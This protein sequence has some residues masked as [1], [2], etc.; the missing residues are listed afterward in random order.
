[1]CS[2]CNSPGKC[3]W[4]WHYSW[5]SL[6]DTSIQN[7]RPFRW[8]SIK[9]ASDSMWKGFFMHKGPRSH[10]PLLN[11]RGEAQWGRCKMF[12]Q[13]SQGIRDFPSP[14]C[15]VACSASLK[16]QKWMGTRKFQSLKSCVEATSASPHLVLELIVS[17][18]FWFSQVFFLR[19]QIL[20]GN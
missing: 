13:P 7:S 11:G 10:A 14:S 17:Y 3:P 6:T 4:Y 8:S 2:Q 12:I 20:E 5:G 19:L 1:M 9:K 16:G 18:N 15:R